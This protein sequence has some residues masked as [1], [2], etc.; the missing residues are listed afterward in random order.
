MLLYTTGS[1]FLK[2]FSTGSYEGSQCKKNLGKFVEN[3]FI[4]M[5]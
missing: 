3:R 1:E 4:S 2:F 5:Y